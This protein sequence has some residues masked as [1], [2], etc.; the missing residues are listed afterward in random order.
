[1]E[2]TKKEF[3]KLPPAFKKRWI[4]ALLSGKYKQGVDRLKRKQDG[5][6][7]HCCLGVAAELCGIDPSPK[8][9]YLIGYKN[10]SVVPKAIR[11]GK[12]GSAA[13]ILSNM[14]DSGNSFKTIAKWIEKNL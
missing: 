14:N 2:K 1:M 4:K 11:G 10:I 8:A 9:S 13:D 3:E 7:K 6:I 5:Q 12:S